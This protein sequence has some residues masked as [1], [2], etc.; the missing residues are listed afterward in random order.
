MSIQIDTGDGSGSK[1]DGGPGG[2]A[3]RIGRV[4]KTPPPPPKGKGIVLLLLG[5]AVIY[6][7]VDTFA[8]GSSAGRAIEKLHEGDPGDNPPVASNSV[9]TDGPDLPTE[10]DPSSGGQ[11]VEFPGNDR[12]LAPTP[13]DGPTPEAALPGDNIILPEG[14]PA[15]VERELR[16]NLFVFENLATA[17]WLPM[18]ASLRALPP[19]LDK[20]PSDRQSELRSFLLAQVAHV[21]HSSRFRGAALE[22][23]A[24]LVRDSD[25]MDSALFDLLRIALGQGLKDDASAPG[26]IALLGSLPDRGG[27]GAVG[28]VDDVILDPTRPL[29]VRVEAA[30]IRPTAGRSQALR[31]LGRSGET[32]PLLREALGE[33]VR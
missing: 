26:A 33:E 17:Q 2:L 4:S 25:E 21:A 20:V 16:M 24:W 19:I 22:T 30:R 10:D 23:A 28:A 29:H 3:N 14:L 1:Q 9:E 6:A 18:Q 32:H 27:A 7:L 8:S 15:R 11:I 12:P 31:E 13:F 5:V